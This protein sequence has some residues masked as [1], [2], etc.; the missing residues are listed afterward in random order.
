MPHIYDNS[1]QNAGG[2]LA[3]CPTKILWLHYGE[4]R[5]NTTL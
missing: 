4:W 5:P 3:T 1:R 2:F